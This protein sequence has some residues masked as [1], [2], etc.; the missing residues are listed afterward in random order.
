M[1]YIR[2]LLRKLTVQTADKPSTCRHSTQQAP[3]LLTSYIS[4]RLR[5]VHIQSRRAHFNHRSLATER[6]QLQLAKPCCCCTLLAVFRSTMCRVALLH[7]S[8]GCCEQ[9]DWGYWR[10]PRGSAQPCQAP[11][12]AGGCPINV[13]PAPLRRQTAE[14]PFPGTVV[15]LCCALEMQF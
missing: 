13:Q 9:Q 3:S 11:D 4:S 15:L 6:A 5:S 2:Q 8:T 12:A 1:H 10:G 14:P 7:L